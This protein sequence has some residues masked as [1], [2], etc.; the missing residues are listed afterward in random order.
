MQGNK[1]FFLQK[2]KKKTGGTVL[3][4]MSTC[5]RAQKSI[6]TVKAQT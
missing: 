2:K 3:S 6:V 5:F 1:N 4:K